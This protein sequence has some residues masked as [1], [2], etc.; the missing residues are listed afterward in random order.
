MNP[1]G[2]NDKPLN[3]EFFNQRIQLLDFGFPKMAF[4]N[5]GCV[6]AGRS[7]HLDMI[8]LWDCLRRNYRWHALRTMSSANVMG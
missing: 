5:R 7:K 4:V 1:Y 2:S 6:R 3:A 8:T